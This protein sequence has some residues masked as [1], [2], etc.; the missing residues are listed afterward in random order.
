MIYERYRYDAFYLYS[1]VF[2]MFSLFS[3][4]SLLS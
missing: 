4:G 3:D 2:I 1:Y